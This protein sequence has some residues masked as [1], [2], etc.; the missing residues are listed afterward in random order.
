MIDR[1]ELERRNDAIHAG[2]RAAVDAGD[3]RVL[4]LTR[5]GELHSYAPDEIGL[6]EV[7]AQLATRRVRRSRV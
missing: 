4:R 1:R 2:H 3:Q 7:T 5:S 6:G